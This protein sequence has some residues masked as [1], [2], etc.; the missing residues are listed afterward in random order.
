MWMVSVCPT[1]RDATHNHAPV[2]KPI[3]KQYEIEHDEKYRLEPLD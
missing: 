3:H 1:E 2:A